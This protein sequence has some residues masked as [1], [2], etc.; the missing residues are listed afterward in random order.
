MRFA[1]RTEHLSLRQAQAEEQIE[2]HE[3]KTSC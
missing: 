2:F 1:S 3:S